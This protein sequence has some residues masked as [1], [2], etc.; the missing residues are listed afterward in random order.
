MKPDVTF[1]SGFSRIVTRHKRF[2]AQAVLLLPQSR[3]L[4]RRRDP[5][6]SAL[7]IT[8]TAC[9]SA[10]PGH[11]PGDEGL[12]HGTRASTRV[13]AGPTGPRVL[14]GQGCPEGALTC[15][16]PGCRR[17]RRRG[18][19]SLQ[20]DEQWAGSL[21]RR[22]APAPL[23]QG[24]GGWQDPGQGLSGVK[25]VRPEPT[26][27]HVLPAALRFPHER[28]TVLVSRLSGLKSPFL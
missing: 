8:L 26:S 14:G 4:G 9:T 23:S 3:S 1:C 5:R 15:S 6:C 10:P 20:R 28:I 7:H 24:A 13:C 22:E 2:A 19:T 16:S 17:N 12:S 25:E 27:Q 21:P 18:P 11:R